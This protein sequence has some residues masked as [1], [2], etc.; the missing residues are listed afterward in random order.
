MTDKGRCATPDFADDRLT[1]ES[2]DM[3][4]QGI[5]HRA[6]A[7][8]YSSKVHCRSRRSASTPRARSPVSTRRLSPGPCAPRPSGSR[9]PARISDARGSLWRL[10]DAAHACRQRRWP[11]NSGSWR[12]TSGIWARSAPKPCCG[13]CTGPDLGLPLPCAPVGA[14]CAQEGGCA[15]GV[16]RAQERF[17]RRHAAMPVLP[18]CQ[19]PADAPARAGDRACRPARPVRRS[20][21][22][23]TMAEGRCCGAGAAAS[24][25][26]ECG[27]P[28]AAARLRKGHTGLDG[29]AIARFQWW[30]QPQGPDTVQLLDAGSRALAYLA[31]V[32]HSHAV[33]AHRLHPG[34]SAYQPGAGGP[35]ALRLLAVAPG[36][37]VIDWF[38]GLGNFTLPLATRAAEVVGVEGSKALVDARAVTTPAAMRPG[39]GDART[40]P[41][42]QPLSW[43]ATCSRWTADRWWPTARP[44]NGC[45]IRRARVRSRWS[46][47]WRAHQA[48]QATGLRDRRSAPG[49]WR[50]PSGIVYVSCNPATL[51]RDAAVCWCIRPVTA[52]RPRV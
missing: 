47:P 18:V 13:R 34:Q 10:Q 43:T 23:A 35:Y 8:W 5:A 30:L 26:V 52:A 17:R 20:N 49:G 45:W 33:Q 3:D 27:R 24:G 36:E 51:A 16:S 40:G 41:W 9:R 48:L 4:A 22:R 21:W 25:A 29:A 1:I 50:C 37:R 19:R 32:R 39:V 28:A 46:R 11:S 7:R 31:G 42:V 14:F 12:T 44:R 2:L 38:C 6:M 15:G